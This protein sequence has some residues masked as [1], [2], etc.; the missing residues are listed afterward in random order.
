MKIL[1]LNAH[2]CCQPQLPTHL[3]N[4]ALKYN[5]YLYIKHRSYADEK[6][7]VSI[8]FISFILV[9]IKFISTYLKLYVNLKFAP[10][11]HKNADLLTITVNLNN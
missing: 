6:I 9:S 4:T 10:L 5:L 2:N 7:E 3:M 1:E 11:M 8:K